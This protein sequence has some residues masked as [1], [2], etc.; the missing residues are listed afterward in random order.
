MQSKLFK[1]DNHISTHRWYDFVSKQQ[2]FLLRLKKFSE[3]IFMERDINKTKLKTSISNYLKNDI[4][5][6][7]FVILVYIK[8]IVKSASCKERHK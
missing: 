7:D 8:F 2:G 6:P 5:D 3:K 1:Q 4:Y